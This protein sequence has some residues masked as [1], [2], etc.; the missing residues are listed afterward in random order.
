MRLFV[1]TPSHS[2][3][4]GVERILE[5]LARGLPSRGIEVVFGL[6][7]GARFN[8]PAR[9]REAYPDIRSVEVD[10]RSGTSWGRRHALRRAMLEVDPDLVLVARMFDAYPVASELKQHGHR[11]RLTVTIQS[12]ESNYFADLDRYEEFVD[13]C[14]TS[15]E[16]IAEVVR[17]ISSVPAVSIPGGVARPRR[18]RNPSAGPLRLGYVGRLQQQ[19]KRVLDLFPLCEELDRRRV[20]YTLD[21]AGEGPAAAELRALLP[22]AR[23]HGWLSTEKLY[24]R[25]Y[26]ELDAFAHFAAWEGL[27]IAPREAMAHGVV[28]V[29]SR[30]AGAE[31]F[32][33]GQNALTFPV[34]D[35]GAAA[36]ALEL[37]HRDRALLE[38]LSHAA[39]ESQQGIRTEAGA[40][41]AWAGAFAAAMA[42]P[43]R[44]G[45]T[46]PKVARDSGLLTRAGV[47]DGVAELWRRLR[48]RRHAD[49]GSE[50]PHWSGINPE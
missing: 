4:G 49:P 11:L 2:L 17:A 8:D 23:F 20:P 37:L 10:G 22:Q 28:P 1:C 3:H 47:P 14:V 33:H 31:D 21:I 24:E 9:F 6:G 50:W 43:Q 7:R 13:L 18:L 45:R 30:F 39:R 42:V 48:R 38:R 40:L 12:Y 5:S 29:V 34:G 32:V 19:Q 26:P 35:V 44:I 16:R 15:G 41:D 36:D 27:T 46:L 25:I